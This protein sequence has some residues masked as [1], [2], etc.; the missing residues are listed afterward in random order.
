MCDNSKGK[1]IFFFGAGASA[2]EGAP[3]AS[4]LLIEAFKQ[5]PNDGKIKLVKDFLQEFYSNDC[6]D[7]STIPTFEE[8]LSPIDICLQK[9]EQFSSKWNYDTLSELRENLIYCICSI[10]HE[11]LSEK[12]KYHLKL[13]D[14]LF[15]NVN[16]SDRYAFI[17][18]NYDILLDNA[19][20]RLGDGS[21]NPKVDIDYAISF[22]NEGTDWRSP[23]ENKVYL[24]KLHGSLNWLFCPTCN[25]I[26]ITPKEKGVMRIFTHSEICEKDSSRQRALIIPPTY[27][28]IY[29]NPYLVSIWLKTEQLLHEANHVIFVGYLM[30]E[31]DVHIKFLLKKA[32]FRAEGTKPKITVIDKKGKNIK[33]PEYSGYKRLFG[34][35]DYQPIGFE[36]FVSRAR[37]F[38]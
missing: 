35:I 31:S 24:L 17:S 1:T 20:V 27:Q 15:Q 32:L 19:L 7:E 18:L 9:Q 13:I 11:K 8:I 4:R 10:L 14:N 23:S 37:D 38:C 5:F 22:R 34:Q 33:S 25:S 36:D 3:I 26:R 2:A 6:L 28:K 29:D 16:D 21:R 30:P 12:N